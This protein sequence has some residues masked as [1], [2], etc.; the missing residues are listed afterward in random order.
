MKNTEHQKQKTKPF[1]LLA[2][3]SKMFRL[4]EVILC[5]VCLKDTENVN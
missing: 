5:F 2:S 1:L 4:I 3:Q